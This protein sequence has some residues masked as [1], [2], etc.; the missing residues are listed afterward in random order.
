MYYERIRKEEPASE[1][2]SDSDIEE[3]SMNQSSS[4]TH[5][6]TNKNERIQ[7]TGTT[8]ENYQKK[9]NNIDMGKTNVKEYLLSLIHI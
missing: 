3:Q 9:E 7:N 5:Q 4:E 8:Y 6:L 1:K 2:E